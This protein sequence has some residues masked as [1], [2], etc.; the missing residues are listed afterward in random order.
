M[1][2]LKFKG[3]SAQAVFDAL[4]APRP[5]KGKFDGECRRTACRVVGAR[6][7]SSVEHAYYCGPCAKEIMRWSGLVGVAPMVEHTVDGG[8][9]HG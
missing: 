5:P 2:T 3:K 6:W 9:E 1:P 4:T 8:T 7:W